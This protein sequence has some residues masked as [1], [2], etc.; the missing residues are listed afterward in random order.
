MQSAARARGLD[1]HVLNASTERDFD[2]VFANLVEL[3]AG[4]LVI[5]ADPFFT[6]R[7]DQLAALAARHAVPAIYE[8][9]EFAVAGGLM[10]YGAS[11]TDAIPSRRL[12]CRPDSQG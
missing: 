3:R 1:L 6:T 10:S 5:A 9:R 8:N 4:A 11:L 7:H 2:A 12:L